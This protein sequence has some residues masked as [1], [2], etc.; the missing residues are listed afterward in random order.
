MAQPI[1]EWTEETTRQFHLAFKSGSQIANNYAEAGFAVAIHQVLYPHDVT[2]HIEA[3]LKKFKP[4]KV[5]LNPSL[6][7]CL[8]RNGER[9][10]K[11]FDTRILDAA[12]KAMHPAMNEQMAA[13][14]DWIVIDTSHQS[15][16]DTVNEIIEKAGLTLETNK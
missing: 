6:E 7:D 13:S 3:R 5:F 14:T 8:Q 12:I 10:N 15:V 2:K 1:P 11:E 9:T 16:E 4:V